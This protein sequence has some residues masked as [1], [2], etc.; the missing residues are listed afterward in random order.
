MNNDYGPLRFIFDLI[1]CLITG[2]LM[3]AMFAFL[4]LGYGA[5]KPYV[6]AFIGG[7]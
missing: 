3:S 6:A 7:F 5:I 4:F 1:M 2:A